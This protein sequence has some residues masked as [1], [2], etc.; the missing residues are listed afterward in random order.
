MRVRLWLAALLMG[1]LM[2]GVGSLAGWAQDHGAAD[3]VHGAGIQRWW[4]NL[5]TRP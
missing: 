2:P 4:W 3:P 5:P 1:V